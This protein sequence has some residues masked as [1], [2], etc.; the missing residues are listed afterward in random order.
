MARTVLIAATL[1][2]KAEEALFVRA[3][4]EARGLSTILADCGTLGRPPIP[5]DVTRQDLARRA[6]HELADLAASGDKGLIMAAMARGLSACTAELHRSGRIQGVIALGGGQGT[7]LGT[8]AMQGL[9]L[10]FPKVMVSTLAAGN[11][12][13]FLGTADIAVFPS[14]ADMLGMN[15]VL[16]ATLGNAARALAGMVDGAPAPEAPPRRAIGATA[17]GVTTA[18]LTRLRG[19][20]SAA[21]AEVTFFHANGVG[22]A[23]MEE[24]ARQGR[25][26]LLLDWTTHE[27]LDE[28]AG[29]LF[30][31]GPGRMTLLAERRIPCLVSTGALDYVVRGPLDEL[32]AEWRRRN[33]IVHNRNITLVRAT[34]AEMARAA[35]LMAGRL[36]R[37]LAPVVVLVPLRGHSEP[38]APGKQFF[39]PAADAAFLAALR[40]ALRP[41]IPVLEVDAH[42]N[43]D[44]FVERA[45]REVGALLGDHA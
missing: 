29:G 9:P 7:A 6:G 24:M 2:T 21:G 45:A 13:P 10:G 14:V 8:A 11:M 15:G 32:D 41:A 35:E 19:L 42:I 28:V 39:D 1:D 30:R 17:F 5:G 31:P 38:N 23:A 44:A 37:A 4:L 16:R 40:G 18:G 3:E 20:L 26:Q 34:A 27:L 36:N 33:L 22:G 43:D 12:R 25:F